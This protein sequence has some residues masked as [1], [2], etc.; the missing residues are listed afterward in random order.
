M[1]RN[2]NSDLALENY[3]NET[4]HDYKSISYSENDLDYCKIL[5]QVILNNHTNEKNSYVTISFDKITLL[6][7]F[8]LNMISE[9]IAKEA[10]KIVS[11]FIKEN[12][13]QRTSFML[14][15]LGNP[16]LTADAVGPLAVQ[17]T[18]IT[19]HLPISDDP[20]PNVSAIAP[21]VLSKTGIETVEILKA[22]ADRINADI[23]IAIDSLAAKSCNRLGCT[24]QISDAGIMP[25]S[26]IG[27]E[28]KAINYKTV[29]RPVISIGV[30]TVVDSA[31]LV[32]DAL[33]KG[34]ISNIS[35][36]LI[37]VL[38]SGK[39]FFVTPKESDNITRIASKLIAEGLNQMFGI[40]HKIF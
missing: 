40:N 21:N 39:S 2:Y 17:Y 3:K 22:I 24:V 25:G 15:G 12:K 6:D 1:Q 38:K 18:N 8:T 13:I 14:A 36:T 27:N 9:V 32:L 29:G 5:K 26:G 4:N 30:P 16:E 28:R 33:E 23:V 34:G 35:D 20:F 37:S 7:E 11:R 31:T 19:R 10:Y